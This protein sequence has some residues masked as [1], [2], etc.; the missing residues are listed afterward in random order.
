MDFTLDD[1][2][3][4]LITNYT[5]TLEERAVSGCLQRSYLRSYDVMRPASAGKQQSCVNSNHVVS[6]MRLKLSLRNQSALGGLQA[7]QHFCRWTGWSG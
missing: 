7:N 4:T 3:V 1:F 5:Q 6:I 2:S